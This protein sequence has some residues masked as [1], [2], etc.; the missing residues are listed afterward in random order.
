LCGILGKI[1]ISGVH[2][3]PATFDAALS[4]IEHR[5]PDDRGVFHMVTQ[6][7]IQ[8][9]LG[10][11]RLS[12]LDISSAGHQPM[13]SQRTG[14]VIVYNGEVYNFK[15]IRNQLEQ[16]GLS[17]TSTCD[18]EVIIAA[19][20]EYQEE[21]VHQLNGMFA[22]GILDIKRKKIVLVRDRLGIKPLYY[23]WDGRQLAFGS[24]ITAFAALPSLTLKVD[25]DAIQQYLMYG[26]IPG[27]LS[28]F[29]NVRKLS[30]GC[31]LQ[32]DLNHPAITERRYWN[33]LEYYA[34]P[35]P[36]N[37]EAEVLEVLREELTKS[38]RRRLISDVPLGAF[39][40]GGIDSSL[41]VSLMRSV[42]TGPVK[43]FTIGFAEKQWDEAPLAKKIA[44]HLGTVHNEFYFSEENTLEIARTAA[45]YNDEPFADP[46]SIPTLALSRFTRQQVTVALS[47]DGGDELFWGYS[48]YKLSPLLRI[49]YDAVPFRMRQVLSAGLQLLPGDRLA[50]W[51]YVLGFQDRVT[52]HL[53]PGIWNPRLFYPR[54]HR[55]TT[56]VNRPWEIGRDVVAQIKELDWDAKTG[57]IDINCSLVDQMLTKIDRA[58][59]STALEVRV[60]FLD[61]NVVQLAARIPSRFKTAGGELKHLPRTLLGEFIPQRLW[62]RPKK[63]F[64]VP[65][66]IW[67]RTVLKEW[68]YD[69]LQSRDHHLSEWLDP[70]EIKLMFNDHVSGRR[71]VGRLIWACLQLAGWDR[72]TTSI[73]KGSCSGRA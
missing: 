21:F 16:R 37:S 4:H 29:Q 7:N 14:A 50:G 35:A 31:I 33:V 51:S 54:L 69:E 22:I 5:G 45:A 64:S 24:E 36:F 8:I 17:F 30:A 38:I 67:F 73:R 13:V 61:Y 71:N 39:L 63:G 66:N 26:Y 3:S 49:V 41:I 34:H 18:T 9:S 40:S 10:H 56:Q 52:L 47:G 42:H 1:T 28:I 48:Y 11:T 72:M 20:D 55:H 62:D 12:I 57:A 19:Y 25:H 2:E 60:P 53:S 6:E 23:Y 70:A 46:A 68:A 44:Q 65:L 58:S 15:E 32:F 43:T 27:P 59:M